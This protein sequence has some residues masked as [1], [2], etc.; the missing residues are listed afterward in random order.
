MRLLGAVVE[1]VAMTTMDS[2]ES[3]SD[4]GTPSIVD[5]PLDYEISSKHM[6]HLRCVL[7]SVLVVVAML[8]I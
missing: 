7:C 1:T 5:V 2:M 4:N 8:Q 3:I 6:L